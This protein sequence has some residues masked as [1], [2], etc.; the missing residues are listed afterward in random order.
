VRSSQISRIKLRKGF[1]LPVSGAPLQEIEP[2]PSPGSV[3]LLGDDF[4]DVRPSLQ[5]EVG[6]R[7]ARG[8][9]LFCDRRDPRIRFVSPAAGRVAA[10]RRGDRRRLVALEIAVEGDDGVGFPR[11]APSDLRGWSAEQTARRLLEAGDWIAL[12][13]R[14]FGRIAKPGVAPAAIFVR[15]MDSRPLAADA[16]VV[17][18]D[19]DDDLQ[20]GLTALSRLTEGPLFLCSRPGV[21]VDLP[22]IERVK[23]VEVAGPHPAGLVGT[24]IHRLLSVSQARQVWYVGYQD[25][26][27]IGR[28]FREGRTDP[29]RV[30]SLS[31]P[32][33]RKPRLVRTV[34]GANAEGLTTGELTPPCRVLSG[35]ILDGRLASR[36]GA[37]LGRHHEQLCAL[38]ERSVEAGSGWW[39]PGWRGPRAVPR[40]RTV[41]TGSSELGGRPAAFYPLD[42]FDR[43]FPLRLP[44]APL[45]RALAAGDA[46][47]A[48]RFG[49][50]ELEEEDLALC[51]YLCPAKLEYGPLLR[52]VL[53]RLEDRVS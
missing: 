45:L 9:T 13:T 25:A 51:S 18:R 3:A 22:E 27:A 6:D 31:G 37:F 12:R 11:V 32:A 4:P 23:R 34:I 8:Q 1:D 47:A 28:L 15:A 43:V 30:I 46:Q 40:W 2:A 53:A 35:S 36:P 14:P 48:A 42:L 20:V 10:V 44:L 38:P 5:V 29:S 19:R 21:T 39:I 33:M 50:L 7:V 17:L 16:A 52:Q 26:L 41:R 49:A 24:H